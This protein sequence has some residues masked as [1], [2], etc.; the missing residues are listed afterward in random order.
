MLTNDIT[1]PF[2]NRALLDMMLRTPLDKRISD[3]LNRD[4]ICAMD[5]K[6][7]DMNIHVVNGNSTKMREIGEKLYFEIHSRIPW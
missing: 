7:Y 5:K 1:I 2:N 6:L 3:E 4:I